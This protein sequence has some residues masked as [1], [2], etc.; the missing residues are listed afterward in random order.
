MNDEIIGTKPKKVKKTTR[1]QSKETIAKR[2]ATMK[3]RREAKASGKSPPDVVGALAALRR[4]KRAIIQSL[5][6][7]HIKDL[8]D[9]ELG[10]FEAIRHL[11]GG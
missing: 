5:C 3:E 11:Q 8:G 6:M 10:V 9:I 7:E 4:S 2:V 1:K